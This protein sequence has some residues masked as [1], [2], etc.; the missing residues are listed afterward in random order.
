MMAASKMQDGKQQLVITTLPEGS[1]PPLSAEELNATV[2][3]AKKHALTYSKLLP[4]FLCVETTNRS[5]DAGGTGDWKRRDTIA[6]LLRY[7]E[8]IETR[9]L[10]ERNGERT[11]LQRDDLN[12]NW[13]I[14]KGEFGALLNLVFKSDSKT[15]F[16]WKETAMAAGAEVQVLKY[17][18]DPK[19]ATLTL[20]DSNRTIGVGFHGLVY[21]DTA[22]G[23][24]RRITLDADNIPAD[25][26]FRAATINVDYDF[27]TI[28]VHEYLM[29]MR[30]VMMIRRGKKQIDLNEMAFR[31]YRRYASQTKI[32]ASP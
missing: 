27:V 5:V 12:A 16:Q 15:E 19:N 26:S 23:G 13:A 8:G 28:G 22:T 6:E 24:I 7:V 3:A 21:V 1:T 10:V 18:V 30:A 14:S 9:T 29:P 25:F 4:N 20:A 11:S 2:E 32:L 17:R 31:G